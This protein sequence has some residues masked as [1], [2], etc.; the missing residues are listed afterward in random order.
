MQEN[1]NEYENFSGMLHNLFPM[2]DMAPKPM[3]EGPSMQQ[4]IKG[5][6]NDAKR[7]YKMIKD[8]EKPI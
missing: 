4:L 2:Y 7:F 6:N 8:V 1:L 3:D 5:P